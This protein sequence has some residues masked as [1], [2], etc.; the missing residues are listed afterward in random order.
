M[1]DDVKMV[2]ALTIS[3]DEAKRRFGVKMNAFMKD[4]AK[5]QKK[6]KI[7]AFALW[8]YHNGVMRQCSMG[9]DE[10]GRWI[11]SQVALMMADQ[12]Q[13]ILE[14][15]VRKVRGKKPQ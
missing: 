13:A 6:H 15:A 1:S 7:E 2:D 4:V 10:I 14:D 5:A 11:A 8:M 12:T 9:T 3:E